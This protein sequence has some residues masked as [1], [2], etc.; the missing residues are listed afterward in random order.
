MNYVNH[1]RFPNKEEEF[2]FF[3]SVH[4]NCYTDF[5]PYQI[6]SKHSFDQIDFAPV[7]ILCGD[8]GSGKS[9]ALN[10]IA[11]K[12][13]V[14]RD[15]NYNKTNFYMDYV[16]QCS[17]DLDK[18]IPKN[19]RII[20]SDDVF[21]Y[22]LNIRAVN[23]GVDLKREDLFLDYQETKHRT[24]KFDSLEDYDALKKMNKT[25][26]LTQSKYVRDELVE[27]IREYSNG[28][29]AFQYFTD[30]IKEQALYILDEPE[31]SLSP[32]KQLELKQFVE[33]SVRFFGCQF[34]ISTH[35]PFILSI[36]GA[37]V[38]NLDANPVAVQPWKELDNVR[39][40][41]EFF[42]KEW[43]DELNSSIS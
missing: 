39:T 3:L 1:F 16:A 20:T 6:L 25:R 31:N 11:E 36:A 28:E 4:L 15:S 33:E 29:S 2:D 32:K 30:K 24:Y 40:Y 21:D 5:F 8:N 17:V 22:L 19:S 14:L 34:I 9:T 18:N 23:D 12:L 10:V 38:Y 27:N 7:T 35:S 26:R 37:K 42:K 43:K 13:G 41:Y